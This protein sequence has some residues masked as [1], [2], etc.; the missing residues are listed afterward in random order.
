MGA[1][2]PPS[3]AS[4]S[5]AIQNLKHTTT[6]HAE[7]REETTQNCVPRCQIWA[8]HFIKQLDRIFHLLKLATNIN[9]S[10]PQRDHRI[11]AM[12]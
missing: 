12:F 3:Q 7:V 10:V 4:R 6:E 2:A 1:D 5:S 9:E 11:Q 8:A